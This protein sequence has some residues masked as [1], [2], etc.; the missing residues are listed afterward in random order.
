[1]PQTLIFV[2]QLLLEV[3]LRVHEKN[4]RARHKNKL[5]HI[6]ASHKNNLFRLHKS[7]DYVLV[8]FTY[9]DLEW[10]NENELR[11]SIMQDDK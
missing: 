7:E 11:S 9:E 10:K 4:I 2:K 3:K 5:S 6:R 8:R 1:M